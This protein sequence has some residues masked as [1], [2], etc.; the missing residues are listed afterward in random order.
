M[1]IPKIFK[2]PPGTG[3]LLSEPDPELAF[4]HAL[5]ELEFVHEK[6]CRTSVGIAGKGDDSGVQSLAVQLA[7]YV[8]DLVL[9][10]GDLAREMEERNL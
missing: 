3:Q 5:F 7:V 4:T 10:W 1:R 8:R 9:G 2:A 6:R